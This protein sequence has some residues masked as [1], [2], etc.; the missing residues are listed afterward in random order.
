MTD[1]FTYVTDLMP[2]VLEMAGL[3]HPKEFRD[4]QVEPMHG[5]SLRPLLS[6]SSDRVYGPEEL[7]AGE[8]LGGKW[9]R[10]G[11]YKAVSVAQPYGPAKWQLFDMSVD[12]GETTDL[13]DAKEEKLNQLRAAWEA[14]AE[15]VNVVP[16]ED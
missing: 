15:E 5:R 1:A 13:S 4:R 8:M 3:E 14:Y 2:T 11:D 16:G 7:I 6:G 10:Q 9:I 12:P